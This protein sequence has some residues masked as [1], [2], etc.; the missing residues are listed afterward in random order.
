ML[1]PRQQSSPALYG[2]TAS[3][4][5]SAAPSG[6]SASNDSKSALWKYAI[7]VILAILALSTVF[8]LV[9]LRR[10]RKLHRLQQEHALGVRGQAYRGRGGFE[11]RRRFSNDSH[12]LREHDRGEDPLEPP[13]P[14]YDD[15]PL[16]QTE[17]G[18]FPPPSQPV[19]SHP[20][21]LEPRPSFVSRFSSRFKRSPSATSSILPVP[22]TTPG[23]VEPSMSTTTQPNFDRVILET[24]RQRNTAEIL[25]NE[26]QT[27]QWRGQIAIRRA[28]SDAGLLVGRPRATSRSQDS[29]QVAVVTAHEV[30]RREREERRRLRRERRERRRRQ[31]D[32]EEGVGLPVYSKNK[33]EG[34]EVLQVGEGL[35]EDASD[36]E[37]DS[38]PEEEHTTIEP[39]V[40]NPPSTSAPRNPT[41]SSL[42]SH[43][44][45]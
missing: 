23:L 15:Q 25:A 21:T 3:P 31:R 41:E 12:D 2:T 36:S 17:R 40:T 33:A 28:L 45:A 13:P 8:R 6:S 19:L 4:S 18:V 26:N 5:A 1:L 16:P 39:P 44:L 27:N 7:V 35:K 29:T 11:D 38:D 10:A 9:F 37:D 43:P 30:E 14:A 20:R 24:T 42:A 22:S 32:L 34:E